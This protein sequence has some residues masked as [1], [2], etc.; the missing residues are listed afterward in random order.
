MDK[1]IFPPCNGRG[2]LLV[3]VCRAMAARA[4]VVTLN[5]LIV[6]ASSVPL[7]WEEVTVSGLARS[8]WFAGS[9]VAGGKLFVFGGQGNMV[10]VNDTGI[11]GAFL[12]MAA[13]AVVAQVHA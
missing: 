10:G 12:T 4:L 3:G 2:D 11:L 9:A 5:L 8:R 6:G 1:R 13:I 7:I